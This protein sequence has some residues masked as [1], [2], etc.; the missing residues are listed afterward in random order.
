MAR[1]YDVRKSEARRSQLRVSAAAQ[2]LGATSKAR[3]LTAK[4]DG[5]RPRTHRQ[6]CTPDVH[7]SSAVAPVTRIRAGAI[8][9]AW[10]T[11]LSCDVSL[12]GDVDP[13]LSQTCF[14]LENLRRS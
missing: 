5:P 7:R 13:A 1:S 12:T 8:H 9:R 11:T 10:L 4:R 3:H 14:D 2:Q 6:H